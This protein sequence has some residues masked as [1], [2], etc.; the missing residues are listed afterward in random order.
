M[1]LKDLV[2]EH[3]LTGVDFCTQQVKQYDWSDDLENC[4]V[5]RFC[6]DGVVYVAIEDPR[7]GYRSYLG[8]LI[9]DNTNTMS[10]QFPAQRVLGVHRTQGRYEDTD[11]ILELID[12]IT[13]KVVLEVGTH[14]C[15]DYYPSFVSSFHPEAMAINKEKSND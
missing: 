11:D 7:D 15:D 3:L 1:E 12:I 14:N 13:G 5:V 9:T 2:G 8:Q 4:Q 6:L 10:N